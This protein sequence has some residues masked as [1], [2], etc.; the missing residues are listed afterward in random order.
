MPVRRKS[1]FYAQTLLQIR[2]GPNLSLSQRSSVHVNFFFP[3]WGD[4]IGGRGGK[5]LRR[6]G[7]HF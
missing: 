5:L 3:V 2:Y 4:V 7:A 6:I 1:S